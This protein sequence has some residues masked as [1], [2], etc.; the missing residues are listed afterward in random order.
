MLVATTNRQ[1]PVWTTTMAS[2]ARAATAVTSVPVVRKL[3]EIAWELGLLATAHASIGHAVL[4]LPNYRA[5]VKALAVSFISTIISPPFSVTKGCS[6]FRVC[7]A[8]LCTKKHQALLVKSL[9]IL[10]A[11]LRGLRGLR[12]RC[13]CGRRL[14]RHRRWSA[15][16]E[17]SVAHIW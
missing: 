17:N 16:S 10:W 13:S 15:P 2:L 7:A 12:A 1:H 14:S 4:L 11:G 5:V 6:P 9:I 8:R 3:V